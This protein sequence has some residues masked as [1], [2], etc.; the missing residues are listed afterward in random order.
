MSVVVS[1]RHVSPAV[2]PLI[3]PPI[4]DRVCLSL[5]GPASCLVRRVR[6]TKERGRLGHRRCS[7]LPM[8]VARGRLHKSAKRTK[9]NSH[10]PARL[11]SRVAARLPSIRV[12][13]QTP[14]ST[15]RS[16][17]PQ[18]SIATWMRLGPRWLVSRPA[19][20]PHPKITLRRT[21]LPPPTESERPD[22]AS[23]SL[24]NT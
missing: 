11:S 7:Q 23:S 6:M 5:T 1:P 24:L 14:L 2:H 16:A 17:K 20:V 18:A 21:S 4:D 22:D 13:S 9:L 8:P 10:G 3:R 15:V 12:G 19:R